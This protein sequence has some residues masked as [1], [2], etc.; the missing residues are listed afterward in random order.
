MSA[1]PNITAACT[2][3]QLQTLGNANANGTTLDLKDYKGPVTFVMSVGQSTVGVGTINAANIQTYTA[4]TAASFAD[5]SGGD[6]TAVVNTANASNIGVQSITFD[7][8]AL[9]RYVR[10]PLTISGTNANIPVTII[11]IGQK[12]RV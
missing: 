2:I 9:S 4:D 8:R 12:E 11:S 7:V 5:V 6:F 1:L 10:V 3:T